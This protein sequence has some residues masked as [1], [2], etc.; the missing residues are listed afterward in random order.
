MAAAMK[1]PVLALIPKSQNAG[2]SRLFGS[3]LP[4]PTG[5]GHAAIHEDV[6]AGD[7]SAV[8][9]HQQG[10]QPGHFIG[11]AGPPGGRNHLAASR[12]LLVQVRRRWACRVCNGYNCS[13]RLGVLRAP[14]WWLKA[15]GQ[16][17]PV[18]VRPARWSPCQL[19][20][21]R[22]RGLGRL[23]VHREQKRASATHCS[24]HVP[25][26]RCAQSGFTTLVQRNGSKS[27]CASSFFSGNVRSTR[28][29]RQVLSGK[30]FSRP[31]LR[32]KLNRAA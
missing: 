1:R 24:H 28:L 19:G 15:L 22:R 21:R 32:L 11:R 27:A 29:P 14:F 2:C 10:G 30:D 31:P 3:K 17:L 7:E 25:L 9:P 4:K 26:C 5:C 12:H 23:P 18:S 20:Q 13:R 6:A 16:P 8:R